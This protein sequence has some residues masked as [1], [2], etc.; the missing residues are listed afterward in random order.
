MPFVVLEMATAA[1]AAAPS[2]TFHE[3]S[4]DHAEHEH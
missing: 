4:D 2:A 1:A 3:E